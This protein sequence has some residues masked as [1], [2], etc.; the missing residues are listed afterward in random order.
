M[1]D[2]VQFV[3][4]AAV[5]VAC[6]CNAQPH[7][8]TVIALTGVNVVDVVRGET[9]T[10][11]A[12]VIEAGRIASIG[13]AIPANARR[14][15]ADGLFA[16][17]GLWDMHVHLRSAARR[18]DAPLVEENSSFLDLFL[19]HG[20]VG[21]REM[22]GDLSDSVLAWR[23]EIR[24]GK[25][26]G[27]RI[28]TVGRKIDGMPPT[29][30]GSLAVKTPADARAA[31]REM[32]QAGA[33][34]IKAN[35]NSVDLAVL[36]AVT[37]EAHR[38]QLRVTGH[39]PFNL[40][41]QLLPDSGMD[42]LEHADHIVPLRISEFEQFQREAEA[43]RGTPWELSR[44]Q[45]EFWARRLYMRDP[46]AADSFYRTL[47]AKAIWITPTL[48]VQRLLYLDL[49]TSDFS[50]DPRRR[51][52]FPAIWDTWDAKTGR[53]SAPQ[54]RLRQLLQEHT[55]Q[56]RAAVVAAHGAGVPMM[57]GS[58]CGANNNYLFPGW[59]LHD[60]LEAL[61]QAGLSPADALRMATINAARW[62]GDADR[63][64]TLEV[65]KAAELVLL[66][67]NPLM[68]ITNTRQVESVVRAGRYYSRADLDKMLA[69]V[70]LRVRAARR[71]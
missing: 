41:V 60:E 28:L 16:I 32:K 62:R 53:R 10:N 52:I 36:Q 40:P 57:A 46:A 7:S 25:R 54:G 61:V 64:G 18:P 21:I 6:L 65:G 55:R 5:C 34:F 66:R 68:R 59:A 51:F 31:V 27:P 44:G 24:L 15:A 2:S 13:E 29:W 42:A 47:A 49:A 11:R 45:E 20:V 43:R 50:E 69:D 39:W 56:T 17:P 22:G 23:E 14:I 70:E 30:P 35:F 33:D 1:N 3:R 19:P 12:V 58:D 63:E 8:Q 38:N 67:A 4:I 26:T 71:N 9:L 37:G 48:F